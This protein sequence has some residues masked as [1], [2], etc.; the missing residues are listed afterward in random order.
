MASSPIT[1][2][3]IDVETM[4]AVKLYLFIFFVPNVTAD[5]DCSHEIKKL[6]LLERKSMTKLDGLLESR[7]ISLPINVHLVKT[8]FFSV[9]IYGC[10]SWTIK[11]AKHQRIYAF[12]LWY[13]RRHLTVP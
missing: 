3:K 1:S 2:W 9:V 5:G 10:E 8:M 4:E 11:K 12:E 7:D 13:W 6:L